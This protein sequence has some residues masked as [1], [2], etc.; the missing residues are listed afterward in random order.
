M[1]ILANNHILTDL[2]VRYAWLHSSTSI[3]SIAVLAGTVD[4]WTPTAAAVGIWVAVKLNALYGGSL[5]EL[6]G[7]AFHT[8]VDCVVPH[9]SPG[10]YLIKC[11]IQLIMITRTPFLL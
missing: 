9:T 5:M 11:H 6:G 7:K 2:Q 4:P 3:F 1:K 8:Q 10:S